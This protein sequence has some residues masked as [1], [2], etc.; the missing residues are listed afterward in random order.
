[1]SHL[2]LLIGALLLAIGSPAAAA[3]FTA[4][5]TEHGI[6]VKIDGKLFTEYLVQSGNKPI[7]WPIIG[8]TG[9]LMTR[10]FPMREVKGESRDHVHQRSMWF[11]H[12]DVSG[13]N[14]WTETPGTGSIRHREFTEVRG[15]DDAKIVAR[16]DWLSPHDKKI[17]ED[18][19]TLTFRASGAGAAS[20]SRS[21]LPRSSRSCLATRR[22]EASAYAC[23]SR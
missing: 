4:E 6:A 21:S 12:G 14:F 3:T 7:L 10:S 19:R 22:K 23:R 20:T 13:V 2:R 11:T 15:G 9:K 17:C 8:P 16:D 5:K 1:M 18:Q